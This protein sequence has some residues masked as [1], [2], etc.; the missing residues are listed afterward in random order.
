MC[1]KATEIIRR[2]CI[3]VGQ[4]SDLVRFF[5]FF[6]MIYGSQNRYLSDIL[7]EIFNDLNILFH[8]SSCNKFMLKGKIKSFTKK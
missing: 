8:G 2:R 7:F 4:K 3:L 6:I 5:F 1:L